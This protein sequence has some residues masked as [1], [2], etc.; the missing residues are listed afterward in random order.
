MHVSAYESVHAC[1]CV[2]EFIY[3][4]GREDIIIII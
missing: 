1:L 3:L 4:C 2:L